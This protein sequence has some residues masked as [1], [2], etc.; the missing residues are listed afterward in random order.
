[1]SSSRPQP[2]YH[3]R[4]NKA[5]DRLTFVK[6]IRKLERLSR[7]SL[8]KYSYYSLG[9]PYLED[10]RLVYDFYPEMSMVSIEE[11]PEILKRQEFHRPCVTTKLKLEQ[12][13][14]RTFV[15]G[16]EAKGKKSVFWLDYTGLQ[17]ACFQE[18]MDLLGKVSDGSMVKFTLC[19]DWKGVFPVDK[20]KEAES[21]RLFTEKYG[22]IVPTGFKVPSN[23]GEFAGLLQDMTRIA[24]SSALPG[25]M[26]TT[27][28]ILSSHYYIDGNPVVFSITG[29]VV[30]KEDVENSKAIFGDLEFVNLDW[31]PPK[32]INLPFLSTKERLHIQKLLPCRD[33]N[34]GTRLRAALGYDTDSRDTVKKLSQYAEFHG[35][36]PYFMKATP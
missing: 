12:K 21:V 2:P 32:E 29:V 4:P 15:D 28:Q 27:F 3:L 14:F 33:A 22:D 30:K 24:V 8:S 23:A 7:S 36:Y 35:F 17:P 5:V 16:Y 34:I 10:F 1:M 9:G 13:D 25:A 26:A 31:A 19:K 20:S 18:F 11:D 6:A